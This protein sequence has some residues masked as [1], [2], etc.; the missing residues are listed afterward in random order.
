LEMYVP[1]GLPTIFF[2]QT[3]CPKNVIAHHL[4]R[5]HDGLH[6]D[7]DGVMSQPV[8]AKIEAFLRFR[9]VRD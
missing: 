8:R 7:A 3:F 1:A 6:V 2:A 5:K 9:R 4:A